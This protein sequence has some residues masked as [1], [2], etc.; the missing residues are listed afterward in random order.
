MKILLAV[1]LL[2]GL[3]ASAAAYDGC[4]EVE[5]HPVWAPTG[6]AGCEVYG[7]GIASHWRGPGVARNDCIWP[8]TDCQT[9]RITSLE[10][11]RSVVVTPTMFCGCYT[12]TPDGRIVDLDP[13]TLRSLE[14]DPAKGLYPVTVEPVGGEYGSPPALLPDTAMR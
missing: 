11:G 9:I 5:A 8:W 13:A 4:Y 3:T 6:V 12:G 1:I 10:T 14:L 2:F 7:E